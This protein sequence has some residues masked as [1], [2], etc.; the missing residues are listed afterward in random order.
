MNRDLHAGPIMDKI[1]EIPRNCETTDRNSDC[2]YLGLGCLG[3]TLKG[4]RLPMSSGVEPLA[5]RYVYRLSA[6]HV[7]GWHVL[8]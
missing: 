3:C 4:P 2:Y 7:G 6:E 8:P 5:H 1:G